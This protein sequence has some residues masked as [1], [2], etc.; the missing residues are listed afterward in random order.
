MEEELSEQKKRFALSISTE[1]INDITKLIK[2]LENS[3]VLI[4]GVTETVKHEIKRQDGGFLRA[5]SA[6]LAASL[7]QP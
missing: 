2:S 5:L 1:D 7:V 3:G 4:N 6:T